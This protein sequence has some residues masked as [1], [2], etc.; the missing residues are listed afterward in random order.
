MES[1]MVW[2]GRGLEAPL[3]PPL[4]WAGTPCTELGCGVWGRR[5]SS[6]P[7]SP[8]IFRVGFPLPES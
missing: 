8:E 7:R 1:Q 4:P 3:V 6:S 5:V 2:V